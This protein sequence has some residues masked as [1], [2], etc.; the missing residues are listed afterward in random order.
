M[1]GPLCLGLQA[2]HQGRDDITADAALTITEAAAAVVITEAAA[3]VFITTAV[4]KS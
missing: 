4:K 1:G 3:A 2:A